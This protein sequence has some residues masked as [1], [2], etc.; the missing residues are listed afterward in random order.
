[1]RSHFLLIVVVGSFLTFS[2]SR[3]SGE[4]SGSGR[5][6][7]ESTGKINELVVVMSESLWEGE[8]GEIF[9]RE[10]Q[11]EVEGLPQREPEFTLVHVRPHAFS[12][13]FKTHRNLIIVETD[14]IRAVK[15][16]R[17]VY[18][19]GQYVAQIKGFTEEELILSIRKTNRD[20]RNKF[21]REEIRRL[22][23][24]YTKAGLR[25]FTTRMESELGLK[26]AVPKDF[27]LNLEG[28]N[29]FWLNREK[30]YATEGLLIYTSPLPN[31]MQLLEDLMDTRDSVTQAY[32]EG[33]LENTYMQI[34]RLYD[35]I[36]RPF[37]INGDLAVEIRGLWRMENDFMGG[38]Y[39]TYTIMDES[40]NR[41]VH[42]DAFV[43]APAKDKRNYMTQL[44]A[45]VSSAEL[46][47]A[48]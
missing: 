48:Q 38:P 42:V 4:K 22:Q 24:A 31:D 26:I 25:S 19:R 12:A 2:C 13:I 30:P 36:M 1:M 33:E 34:E 17:D 37:E 5:I 7:P 11:K 8:A 3:S 35:P 18:A 47:R 23:A 41:A 44:E 14:T 27:R 15:M 28:E 21:H 10:F 16:A 39:M 20:I 40:E 29:F 45:I 43:F 9:R 32:V 46:I 6:L